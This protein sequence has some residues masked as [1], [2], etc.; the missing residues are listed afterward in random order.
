LWLDWWRDLLLVKVGLSGEVT[1]VD[2]LAIL[3]D[4]AKGYNLTQIKAFINDIQVAGAQLK[5]NANSQLALEVLMFN[6]PE[7]KKR[8]DANPSAQF[9]V[10]YG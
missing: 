4:T 10:K 6:I 9:E 1:N 8:S 2:R 7:A 3:I 5:Q